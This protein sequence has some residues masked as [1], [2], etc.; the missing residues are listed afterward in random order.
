MSSHKVKVK[1]ISYLFL[2]YL[3]VI[4]S[5]L[6]YLQVEMI[7]CNSC[8]IFGLFVTSWTWLMIILKE[9]MAIIVNFSYADQ[10]IIILVKDSPSKFKVQFINDHLRF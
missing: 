10:K 7:Q 5:F 3:F 4:S 2:D 1:K 9:A 8:L 6:L